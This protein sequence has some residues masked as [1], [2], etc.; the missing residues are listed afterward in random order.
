[1]SFRGGHQRRCVS[2]SPVSI[3]KVG[4]STS[5]SCDLVLLRTHARATSGRSKELDEECALMRKAYYECKRGQLDMRNRL[6]GNPQFNP[7]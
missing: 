4:L 5:Q 7:R 6:R 1:M 2:R 3:A